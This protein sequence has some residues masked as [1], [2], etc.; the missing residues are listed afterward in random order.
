[1]QFKFA[2][3]QRVILRRE[4][5]YLGAWYIGRSHFG[6]EHT[7]TSVTLGASY[8]RGTPI[9]MLNSGFSVT[10]YMIDSAEP[11]SPFE[12]LIADYICS[13]LSCGI[14]EAPKQ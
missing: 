6:K 13:E 5:P 11:L 2:A 3:G 1:M 7:I 14:V 4:D 10:E 9:Y 8:S 12:C